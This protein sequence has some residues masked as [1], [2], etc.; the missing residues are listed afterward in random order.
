M[1]HF[2]PNHEEDGASTSS[3]ILSKNTEEGCVL[4]AFLWELLIKSP[5]EKQSDAELQEI[6]GPGVSQH[7]KNK[8]V[9]QQ[10]K[11]LLFDCANEAIETRERKNRRKKHVQEF[12][13]L[14]ELGKNICEQICS[15]GK[16]NE[17]QTVNFNVSS[18]IED[19]DYL[20]QL[21]RKIGIEIGDAIMNEI[22]QE[23]IDLFLQ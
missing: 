4:S 23:I 6:I 2:Q 8:R 13:D 10:S 21:N 5:I 16:Q 3:T 17:A 11:Q 15:W 1:Y 22:I 18:T 7:L 20:Q 14:Q 19:W 9:L 12:K